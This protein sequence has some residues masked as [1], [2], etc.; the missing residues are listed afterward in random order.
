MR[1]TF[2]ILGNCSHV[3]R[4]VASGKF[5]KYKMFKKTSNSSLF[6]YTLL[7]S[8]HP[9]EDKHHCRHSNSRKPPNLDIFLNPTWLLRYTVDFR[10]SELFE[11]K[12]T[13]KKKKGGG[14]KWWEMVVL[15]ILAMTLH[16]IG[17]IRAVGMFV[18]AYNGY[19]SHTGHMINSSSCERENP[20][21]PLPK[22]QLRMIQVALSRPIFGPP[23]KHYRKKTMLNFRDRILRAIS[24]V[25][26]WLKVPP[27]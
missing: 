25:L 19:Q 18:I 15:K 3:N 20:A 26:E 10:K 7:T 23:S 1:S 2:S 24:T 17:T 9:T 4:A 14:K 16:E 22:T 6:L 27:W 11:N 13:P 5:M 21:L 12:N 8:P